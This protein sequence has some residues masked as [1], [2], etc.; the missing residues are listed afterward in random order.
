MTPPK[1]HHLLT[2]L[3][4][5]TACH[6]IFIPEHA[7]TELTSTTDSSTSTLATPVN[8]A[9][10]EGS[11]SPVASEA[12]ATSRPEPSSSTSNMSTTREST[13][14]TPNN[15]TS[16]RDVTC[17]DGKREDDEECDDGP[18]DTKKCNHNCTLTTCEDDYINTEAG[19]TCLKGTLGC[20]DD[21][22]KC[23]DK[24]INGPAGVEECDSDTNCKNCKK[25]CGNGVLDQDEACDEGDGNSDHDDAFC[26]EQCERN[27]L[28]VFITSK[29]FTGELGDSENPCTPFIAALEENLTAINISAL[30]GFRPWLSTSDGSLN[31]Q[32]F[33]PKNQP[34]YQVTLANNTTVKTL[35]ATSFNSLTS[36]DGGPIHA[37]LSTEELKT[38]EGPQ[39]VWT[40][41]NGL[42]ILPIL[43]LDD[44]SKWTQSTN[45]YSGYFG[46]ATESPQNW[47]EWTLHDKTGCGHEAR[48][49]CFEQELE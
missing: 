7:S 46:V 40:F 26:T 27:G 45:S 19:E 39:F 16:E 2:S 13:D 22:T 38:L 4:Y 20:R 37:I 17:G 1:A 32:D 49:Y 21:C 6:M 36:L 28:L 34:Y 23:G 9:S 41:T 3:L 10:D 25:P 33:S 12:S 42:G 31:V 43:T 29:K 11:E 44:C 14:S 24:V 18:S 48:L 47:W 35:T 5:L 30:G 8:T 15:S